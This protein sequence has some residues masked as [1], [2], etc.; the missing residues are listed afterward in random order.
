MAATISRYRNARAPLRNQMFCTRGRDSVT[1]R[2][3]EI[4][5]RAAKTVV[6]KHGGRFPTSVAADARACRA[7]EDTLRTPSRPSRSIKSVPIVEAN[8]ARVL[9]SP[10]QSSNSHRCSSRPRISLGVVRRNFC[11]NAMPRVYN[12][13]L[14]DLGAVDLHS[15]RTAMRD[16][17][18]KNVLPRHESRNA[19]AQKTA[20][21]DD[22]ISRR[23]CLYHANAGG[24]L[25]RRRITAGA[26][27]GSCRR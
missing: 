12:S 26:E 6:E 27:C 1:I 5:M 4:F 7:S 3:R 8:T 14:M 9:S 20:I 22:K 24:V 15:T 19:P 23:P 21:A 18:G 2:A 17:P 16:L 11:Q 10:F 25:L 13:A